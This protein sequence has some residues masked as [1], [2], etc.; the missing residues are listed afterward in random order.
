MLEH[1]EEVNEALRG[2][3]ALQRRRVRP[4][5]L[6]LWRAV[7]PNLVNERRVIAA[8]CGSHSGSTTRVRLALLLAL[9]L[10]QA[11]SGGLLEHVLS[12]ALVH[13]S[14]LRGDVQL[15]GI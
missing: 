3:P 5:Y 12:Q 15:R 4:E 13:P 2:V 6:A 9:L 8:R 14:E 1:L 11:T 7:D 10:R